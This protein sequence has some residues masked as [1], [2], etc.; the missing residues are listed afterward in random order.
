M[1]AL[2]K[3][4][5]KVEFSPSSEG[6]G[7][8]A[9]HGSLTSQNGDLNRLLHN[10]IQ[11]LRSRLLNLTLTNKLLHFSH[12]D[13]SRGFVRVV[14]EL[15]D[16]VFAKLSEG[17]MTFTPLP[18][19]ED[20]PR[21]EQSDDFRM[22][23][24]AARLTDEQYLADLATLERL[25][26]TAD[27][28]QEASRIDRSLKD[29]L[30]M[31]L[32]LPRRQH[33]SSMSLAE[34][35]R[36]HGISP[37][38]DLPDKSV[39]PGDNRWQ[40]R[41]LQLLL[42]PEASERKLSGLLDLTNEYL[43]ETGINTL[44]AAYGFL[45]WHE[46]SS[47][48]T[49]RWA[50]LLLL[51]LQIKRQ[52]DGHVYV[53][54]ISGTGNEPD[55]NIALKEKL[56][57]DFGLVLPERADDD[58]PETYM[59]RVAEAIAS[60]KR[61]RVRRW[62]TVGIFP[63]A[64]MALY[65]DLD[66]SRWPAS[67]SL[68]DHEVLSEMLIGKEDNATHV[69]T[70]VDEAILSRQLPLLITDADASQSGAIIDALEGGRRALVIKGPPGTGK[71]QTI[72]NLIAAAVA[73]GQRVL[74]VADKLAALNV[75]HSRL[76]AAE[77]H[78]FCLAL[79]SDKVRKT[80]V[81]KSLKERMDLSGHTYP[82]N[83]KGKLAELEKLRCELTRYAATLNAPLGLSGLT[84]HEVLWAAQ[85]A[86]GF[87]SRL[88]T[89]LG[90]IELVRASS[91]TPDAFARAC[92]V[93]KSVEQAYDRIAREGL[94][95][96]DHPW[97]GVE[98]SP[99]NPFDASEIH[100][101]AQDWKASLGDLGATFDLMATE[102]GWTPTPSLAGIDLVRRIA[103]LSL[104]PEA[105]KPNLLPG[106]RDAQ[107]RAAASAFLSDHEELAD[108]DRLLSAR[109]E[110][111][112]IAPL[113]LEKVVALAEACHAADLT[114]AHVEASIADTVTQLVE[115]R[116]AEESVNA[117]ASSLGWSDK[118]TFMEL[119]QLVKAVDLIGVTD[120]DSLVLGSPALMQDGIRTVLAKAEREACRLRTASQDVA[121]TL[122]IEME[123]VPDVIESH[124]WEL[125]RGGMFALLRGG[126]RRAKRFYRQHARNP[127]VCRGPDMASALENAASHLRQR[128]RFEADGDLAGSCGDLFKG[129]DTDFRQLLRIVAFAEN[130]RTQLSGVTGFA[131]CA[132]N[133]LLEK[134]MAV[135]DNARAIGEGRPFAVLK[136]LLGE[137]PTESRP[138]S[139]IVGE[140][141]RRERQLAELAY[142]S[143]AAGFT[144]KGGRYS[145]LPELVTVA[146]RRAQ[147]VDAID[148]NEVAK[149]IYGD[150]FAGVRT[151]IGGLAETLAYAERLA[152]TDSPMELKALLLSKDNAE[153]G[154]FLRTCAVQL[155]HGGAE[156][157]R[158]RG[159]L[160]E[161]ATVDWQAFFGG[162]SPSEVSVK[163]IDARLSACLDNPNALIEWS[164]L[165][166]AIALARRHPCGPVLD[167]FLEEQRPLVG[168]YEGLEFVVYRAMAREAYELEGG[169]LAR[170]SGLD[171]DDL[172][173]RFR[174]LDRD[175][176]RLNC[177]ALADELLSRPVPAGVSRGK[178]AEYTDKG[179]LRNEVG[180]SSRHIPLRDLMQR[181]GTAIQALK[182]C[183]MMSPLSIAQYIPPGTVAF[184]LV[185]I[186]EASQ[187]K[188][189]E[190]IGAIARAKRAV[191][192]GD[193]M[194]LPPTSFFE[195]NLEGLEDDRED[196]EAVANESILDL[197][198]A[199][200]R[201]A[202][203]LRWHYRSRHGSLI[204]FSNRDFY[205]D[206]LIVFPSPD[207][208]SPDRGVH[209][210]HVGGVYEAGTNL[211]EVKAIVAA[212]IDHMHRRPGQSLGL[213][214]L[215]QTQREL[216]LEEMERVAARD[217][218]A[219]AYM[220]NWAETLE[221][222]VV[223]N[224]ENVQ[225]DERD[226]IFIS[227]VYGPDRN[228]HVMQRFGPINARNGH[229]RLNVLFSRA[230]VQTVVFTSMHANE[231]RIEPR[232]SRGVHA[233]R[234]YLEFAAT[235]VLDS[236]HSG[237]RE[238]DSDFEICVAQQ[239]RAMGCEAVAQVGV[240]GYFIDIGV[241][242]PSY[243]NGYVLGIECDG[244]TYHSG[245]VARDRDRLRQEVLEARGWTIHRIWSTDWFRNPNR[246]IEK[247]RTRI[248][249][250]IGGPH[251]LRAA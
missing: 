177:Q 241:K 136:Q 80:E 221:P 86:Q 132:R 126:Y 41:Q 227:T 141:A 18:S 117:L 32:G 56:R 200:Y 182:P 137:R 246:E 184:D 52:V 9:T 96:V 129:L 188:P 34:H 216:I 161:A 169:L 106:L 28:G 242:H 27:A 145:E 3:E 224:L 149:L 107:G 138:L 160:Q 6:T 122:R 201:P 33:E 91:W 168:L 180:K 199:T 162:V 143:R 220:A 19:L 196:A 25:G 48:E 94:G 166:G 173:R 8:L 225:G 46:D 240:A 70:E 176:L 208:R 24:D 146:K 15:P 174:Q 133:A 232:S 226:C 215:N 155:E 190:A 156:A 105:C 170:L 194:Q 159:Q 64:R 236:G 45:Q 206:Q 85:R 92:V 142:E 187:M 247:L 140:L 119:R 198:L 181:A 26:E 102:C 99:L 228:G 29:R 135:L 191:I 150:A 74:F 30:R 165:A 154:A 235:G 11:D 152:S 120:R 147:L 238:P 178:K 204:A 81:L 44:Y 23:V 127:G 76:K 114:P 73:R 37:S 118:L 38:F 209:L 22:A 218:S 84:T 16:M 167:A 250:L 110:E 98:K 2:P 97:R 90:T 205:D 82:V 112:S 17:S 210:R 35:A 104:P 158:A 134:E 53:Y 89:R 62:V 87:A 157:E 179:L 108:C 249:G 163:A 111:A 243:P 212:A 239:I 193:P 219:V 230:K 75:V 79:H 222:F 186:D 4:E 123:V 5:P 195:R 144:I 211:T 164:E 244:A 36:L 66:P 71:S 65:H 69:A 251:G 203:T 77:L 88:P 31:V 39:H 67:K 153:R 51:P 109:L 223:K 21:D 58:T 50:P 130:V 192:V 213:V 217:D 49:T 121:R 237:G 57:A 175:I 43:Q 42:L 245:R 202:R 185:I 124:A 113:H 40:D 233:L 125:R 60:E 93:L 172:C 20:E 83:R 59:A 183:F 116:A 14:D 7:L 10:K 148:A 47:S 207:D 229:R 61:W 231:I 55:I 54:T 234:G 128:K 68:V 101:A 1:D 103:T 197:A 115:L 13:R 100:T 139:E 12:S 248:E 214:A 63:F 171:Q 95:L 151:D 78:H 131:V 72:T 189:E